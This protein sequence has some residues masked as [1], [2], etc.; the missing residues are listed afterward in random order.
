MNYDS[1]AGLLDRMS[2]ATPNLLTMTLTASIAALVVMVLHLVLRRVP[3]RYL[4]ILWL[5]VLIRMLSPYGYGEGLVSLIPEGVSSGRAAEYILESGGVESHAP[6]ASSVQ[7]MDIPQSWDGALA[8]SVTATEDPGQIEEKHAPVSITPAMVIPVIW[9]AGAAGMLLWSLAAYI[10]VRRRVAEAVRTESGDLW[11][12]YETDA[13]ESPFVLGTNIYLPVGLEEPDRRYVLLHERAHVE[14]LDAWLKGFFWI[15]L[16][17][18][19][20]NPVLWLA[21]RLLC[22]DVEAACDQKVIDGFAPETKK[23][24]VAGYAAAL[25]H[26]GRKEKLPQAVLPFGEENARERIK[27]VL[28]YRKPAR[29]VGVLVMAVCVAV[30]LLIGLNGPAKQAE[31]LDWTDATE[32]SVEEILYNL[33]TGLGARRAVALSPEHVEELKAILAAQPEPVV[34][35]LNETDGISGLVQAAGNYGYTISLENPAEVVCTLYACPGGDLGIDWLPAKN[36]RGKTL[37]YRYPGLMDDPALQ[38]W[39][40]KVTLWLT[41]HRADELYDLGALGSE[42]AI[43]DGYTLLDAVG[44]R[45][46]LP[47]FAADVEKNGSVL[48]FRLKDEDNGAPEQWDFLTDETLFHQVWKQFLLEASCRTIAVLDD[49]DAIRYLFPDGTVAASVSLPMNRPTREGFRNL[50]VCGFDRTGMT[51]HSGDTSDP[52]LLLDGYQVN[53]VTIGV[54]RYEYGN[55]MIDFPEELTRELVAVL[56]AHPHEGYRQ[57]TEEDRQAG[58]GDLVP[59]AGTGDMVI[60]SGDGKSKGLYVFSDGLGVLS[61]DQGE[62]AR[63]PG[64]GRANDFLLWQDHARKWLTEDWPREVYLQCTDPSLDLL[65]PEARAREV[66]DHLGFTIMVL[67]PENPVASWKNGVLRLNLAQIDLENDSEAAAELVQNH[68]AGASRLLQTVLKDVDR[69]VYITK[70]GVELEVDL[71]NSVHLDEDGFVELFNDRS[72]AVNPP[73]RVVSGT[74]TPPDGADRQSQAAKPSAAAR[75]AQTTTARTAASSTAPAVSGGT[76]TGQTQGEPPKP[77][78][79]PDL[80]N[81]SR[82]PVSETAPQES[83]DRSSMPESLDLYFPPQEGAQ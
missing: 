1:I 16:S 44:I 21:Y 8:G 6:A 70:D 38:A 24:E 20:F 40:E 29:W 43:L 50:Y 31:P 3:R 4:M 37:H 46:V 83:A 27:N 18:H 72:P 28:S 41:V 42:A 39:Q 57:A 77:E 25:Y 80:Q 17:L 82:L 15:A 26:L 67:D 65:S 69:V 22:R 55:L 71:T 60:L 51:S 74:Y 52:T 64:L 58:H 53:S 66:L 75:P 2:V 68:L 73:V 54:P 61:R 30:G 63:V 35:N 13:I 33:D 81:M 48:T 56:Q 76:V 62:I 59:L 79:V 14:R 36:T 5:F 12:A 34:S 23:E 32:G 19:W 9:L 10:R 7:T 47:S 11:E 45:D 49:I 78:G